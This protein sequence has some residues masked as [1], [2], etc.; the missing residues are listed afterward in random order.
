MPQLA[1]E[2]AGARHN[3]E[4]EPSD[5]ENV[6]DAHAQVR[7]ALEASSDLCAMDI[8]TILIGSYAR[9]VSIRRMKDVDVFSK[10]EKPDT[11]KTGRD[12]LQLFYDVLVDEFVHGASDGAHTD[13]VAGR[14]LLLGRQQVAGAESTAAQHAC[15]LDLDLLVQSHPFGPQ[16]KCRLPAAHDLA[17]L[18]PGHRQTQQAADWNLER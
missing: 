17:H 13:A 12:L 8:D 3:V 5:V 10:L 2:F 7:R 11:A 1:E 15:D 9:N 14:K 4:P 18:L 6:A 16:R